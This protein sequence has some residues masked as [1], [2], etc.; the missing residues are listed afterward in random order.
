[1]H[2]I[3]PNPITSTPSSGHSQSA[4]TTTSTLST[5]NSINSS[6]LP[7]QTLPTTTSLSL[8]SKNSLSSIA[9]SLGLNNPSFLATATKNSPGNILN[10]STK[11]TSNTLSSTSNLNKI[12]LN[13]ST[14]KDS[15][16]IPASASRDSTN[17]AMMNF[18]DINNLKRLLKMTSGTST[19]TV[20]TTSTTATP[21]T[22]SKLS[23]SM[24]IEALQSSDQLLQKMQQLLTLENTIQKVERSDYTI[25]DIMNS[26]SFYSQIQSLVDLK[27]M[28]LEQLLKKAKP[29]N[30]TNSN[31]SSTTATTTSLFNTSSTNNMNTTPTTSTTNI[32]NNLIDVTKLQEL[33]NQNK[34]QNQ[35]QVL[36]QLLQLV[37]SQNPN[38]SDASV[39]NFT[40]RMDQDIT[41]SSL[42]ASSLLTTMN[43]LADPAMSTITPSTVNAGF[44]YDGSFNDSIIM[45]DYI[46]PVSNQPSSGASSMNL[47]N[48]PIT[49]KKSLLGDA[50]DG[51]KIDSEDPAT[52][53][54][55]MNNYLNLSFGTTTAGQELTLSNIAKTKMPSLVNPP[56]HLPGITTLDSTSNSSISDDSNHNI[57]S[58]TTDYNYL[59]SLSGNQPTTTTAAETLTTQESTENA[60]TSAAN[61][62]LL[63]NPLVREHMDFFSEHD[64]FNSINYS[65]IDDY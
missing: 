36:K 33:L 60:T 53:K 31:V 23:D 44:G 22:N 57:G 20:N 17:S 13:Q 30:S 56:F 3:A 50:D 10:G 18:N 5:I 61:N 58:S 4:I 55:I 29:T 8:S 26:D 43:S 51:M 47:N 2:A 45:S 42:N 46:T 1:M 9:T 54:T 28:Q 25:N 27:K 21:N 40:D 16:I 11:D 35:E 65:F 7:N 15:I 34:G 24:S 41:T 37:N 14:S 49:N 32:S 64:L 48:S 59:I 19:S 6:L 38:S 62:N 63:S 12:N 39:N 52:S